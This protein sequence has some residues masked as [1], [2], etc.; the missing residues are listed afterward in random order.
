MK[1]VTKYLTILAVLSGLLISGC[2]R[3]K[4]YVPPDSLS[5]KDNGAMEILTKDGTTYKLRKGYISNMEITGR[6]IKYN[7]DGTAETFTGSI[8]LEEISIVQVSRKD[9]GTSLL[10]YTAVGILMKGTADALGGGEAPVQVRIS[11]PSS[12]GGGWSCPHVFTYDG[13][14]YNFE[15]ET[16]AGAICQGLERTNIEPLK[17]LKSIDGEYKLVVANQSPE[18]Q[19]VNEIG[20]LSASHPSGTKIIPD[21][22]GGLHTI[23][24]E[25]KPTAAAAFDNTNILELV[26]NT[27]DNFFESKIHTMDLSD[28]KRLRDGLVCEFEKPSNI[29]SGKLVIN[30]IN[31]MLG[32]FALEKL[33]SSRG[34]NKLNW[35]HQLNTDPQERLKLFN[36]IKREGWLEVSLMIDGQWVTQSWLPDFGPRKAGEKVVLL[37]LSQVKTDRVIIKL[38]SATDLWRIDKVS[39]DYTPDEQIDITPVSMTKAVNDRQ[40]DVTRKMI[41][42][43]A[44]Y[45]STL[46]GDY[47]VMT[48]DAVD[49]PDKREQTILLKSA[50]YYYSWINENSEDDQQLV[51]RILTE[52]LFGNRLHLKEWETIRDDFTIDEPTFSLK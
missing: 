41:K 49:K 29:N 23:R 7:T 18:S 46:P 39:I 38:E 47:A 52:P 6:G 27:D 2:G 28:D 40:E 17:Y 5:Y 33:F 10:G 1:K 14:K 24:E 8:P 51:D 50:G 26:S 12:G 34:P 48:F 21:A 43:D 16:F 22:R 9:A 13:D 4:Q 19:H 20:L 30:G 35:Y 32:Y 37:D 3:Y 42:S 11:Y 25:I 36:W 31:T 15:S 45:Y 44:Q